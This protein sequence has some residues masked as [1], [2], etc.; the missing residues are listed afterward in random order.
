MSERTAYEPGT[1]SWVDLTTPDPAA[2][3]EFYGGLFGWEADDAG[4]VEETGG[5]A[6]FRLNGRQVAGVGPVMDPNQPPVWSTYISTDDVDAAVARAKVAG[7]QAIVE[8]MDVMDAGR[9]AFVA[10]PAGGIVGFWQ[11]RQHIGA[12]LVN[13]PGALTWNQLHTRDQPA[14]AAFYDAV[15]GWGLGDVGGMPVFNLG[16][17]GIAGL[18]DMPP[19]TPDEVPA[20]WMT[21]FAVSDAD[22]TAAKASELGGQAV[23]PPGDIE[24]VGRFALLADPQGVY[25]GIISSAG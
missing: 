18:M 13:E 2:A 19:G 24:G 21:I 14:A 7:A 10:H 22:A 5:Y 12:E 1:P 16:E 23:V 25:F 17:S 15:F 3:K 9:L 8:P 20:F 11:P 4:P 6:M